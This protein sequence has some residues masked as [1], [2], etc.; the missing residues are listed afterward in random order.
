[1][2]ELCPYQVGSSSTPTVN[3]EPVKFSQSTATGLEETSKLAN[4]LD[5]SSVSSDDF[6]DAEEGPPLTLSQAQGPSSD[7]VEVPDIEGNGD[8][9]GEYTHKKHHKQKQTV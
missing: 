9:D 8:A 5:T 1:M 3:L 6:Y 7:I 4:S 2:C